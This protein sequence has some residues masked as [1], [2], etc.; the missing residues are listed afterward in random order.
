[1]SDSKIETLQTLH[2][3]FDGDSST[4]GLRPRIRKAAFSLA[5]GLKSSP[6]VKEAILGGLLCAQGR[7]VSSLCYPQRSFQ[8][9]VVF[10]DLESVAGKRQEALLTSKRERLR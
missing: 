9:Q 1:V 4:G 7:R 8:M 2:C 5:I 10:E 3:G 6:L